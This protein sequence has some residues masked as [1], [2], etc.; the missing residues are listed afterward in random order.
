MAAGGAEPV[1]RFFRHQPIT[2]T[3]F[4]VFTEAVEFLLFANSPPS[5]VYLLQRKQD[6]TIR[7][8]AEPVAALLAVRVREIQELAAERTLEKLHKRPSEAK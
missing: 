3:V 1:L 7:R 5:A 8:I 6:A 4:G 2:G